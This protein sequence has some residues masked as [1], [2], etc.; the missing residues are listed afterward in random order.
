[1]IDATA[2]LGADA[3]VLAA[4]GRSVLA[5][6]R[7]PI[8][9]RLLEDAHQRLAISLPEQ[10]ARLT[11][12]R[13]DARTHLGRLDATWSRPAAIVLDPMYPVRRSSS[14]LPP[15][16]MQLLRALLEGEA[17]ND[18]ID[19]LVEAAF[20]TDARRIVLKRP[21]E[22]PT[23]DSAGTPTFSI[24]SKLVRWDVWDRG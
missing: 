12:V 21:P 22:A 9:C 5:I 13:G 2:G 8:L 1:M 6:E 14:A 20:R 15:K 3:G 4:L 11:L 16:P 17:S 24:E 19:S 23:P 7:N 10:A 18:E